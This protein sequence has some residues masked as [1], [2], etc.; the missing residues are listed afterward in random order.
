MLDSLHEELNLRQHKPYIE[1]P[2]S[3][4]R[5]SVDLSLE[6]W[7]NT[8][9]RDW[10]F[11]LFL[12][13]GQFKSDLICQTCHKVS[14]T[15]D[16]FTSI[17]LSL[18]EPSKVVLNVIVYRLPNQLKDLM[19]VNKLHQK[20]MVRVESG[21]SDELKIQSQSR[22]DSEDVG[23]LKKFQESFKYATN[24]QPIHICIKVDKEI[25]IS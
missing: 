22:K 15:F 17:P 14:T 2:D 20:R 18:P 24:D 10:S 13:Y 6:S 12:F 4:K 11:I 23:G 16:N 8:L 9:R 19:S 3:E 1:N 21:R 25:K 5:D 7:S